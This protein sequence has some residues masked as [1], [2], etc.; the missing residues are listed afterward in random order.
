MGDWNKIGP[1]PLQKQIINIQK[2]PY[3]NLSS[4]YPDPYSKYPDPYSKDSYECREDPDKVLTPALLALGSE[5]K[6]DRIKAAK[7]LRG[8]PGYGCVLDQMSYEAKASIALKLLEDI[9]PNSF[10]RLISRE[11]MTNRGVPDLV[12]EYPHVLSKNIQS[13]IPHLEKEIIAFDPAAHFLALVRLLSSMR[14][15]ERGRESTDHFLV[16]LARMKELMKEV[17]P[18]L[19]KM[20]GKRKFKKDVAGVILFLNKVPSSVFAVNLSV[21]AIS[22][23]AFAGEAAI[24]SLVERYVGGFP[25]TEEDVVT[26]LQIMKKEEQKIAIKQFADLLSY[27]NADVQ[28]KGIRALKQLATK[29]S[30]DIVLA[31]TLA[32]QDENINVRMEAIAALSHL[33]NRTPGIHLALPDLLTIASNPAEQETL[34][35]AAQ[36]AIHA[37][38]EAA[39]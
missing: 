31:L 22:L 19:A 9:D 34:R 23:L 28:I 8:K 32:L 17:L 14:A 20:L 33:A 4:L 37:I 39:L 11:A 24:P 27:S 13:I 2:N 29:D 16:E 6:S 38:E 26:A 35:N 18:E 30:H 25:A 3:L 5:R 21:P 10:R 12:L 15:E 7:T 36:S 1:L